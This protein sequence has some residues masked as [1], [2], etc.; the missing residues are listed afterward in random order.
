MVG[1]KQAVSTIGLI[2]RFPPP[3]HVKVN[4]KRFSTRLR[5]KEL[6]N[7]P[8][9]GDQTYGG[10]DAPIRQARAKETDALLAN[11]TPGA[12]CTSWS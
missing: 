5:D 6:Y 3:H 7:F 9:V 12:A 4:W 11:S 8:L 1:G 10:A 2:S